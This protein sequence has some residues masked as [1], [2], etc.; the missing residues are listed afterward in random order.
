LGK[1]VAVDASRPD[2]RRVNRRHDHDVRSLDMNLRQDSTRADSD[3]QR[4]F[5]TLVIHLSARFVKV[6]AEQVDSE[7]ADAQRRICDCLQLDSSLL[8]QWRSVPLERFRLTHMHRPLGG[9]PAPGPSEVQA[10]FPWAYEQLLAGRMYVNSSLDDLPPEAACDAASFRRH[11]VKSNVGI[12]LILGGG[13]LLG[14]LTFNTM[15]T[16]RTW[17]E[18]VLQ[19]LQLVA[20]IFANALARKYADADARLHLREL[21]HLNRV[22]TIGVLTNAFAHELNQPLGAILRNTEA[23]ELLLQHEA[24]DLLELRAIVADIKRDDERASGVI[25]RLRALLRQRPIELESVDLVRLVNDVVSLAHSAAAARG[26]WVE[27]DM[28]ATLPAVRCDRVHV[29]QVLLNLIMNGLDAINEAPDGDPRVVI[30]ARTA[31]D[32]Q[33]EVSV[34]DT[35][36]GIAA[37][38]L[39]RLFEPFFTT[40]ASG[41][42]MG[43]AISR[44]L[45]EAHGGR[46]W[47]SDHATRGAT[48]R[49][50]LPTGPTEGIA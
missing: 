5:E 32:H 25:D 11:G 40:K 28:P 45:I 12:P 17:T 18:P 41:T 19:R 29:Q 20:Q 27:G 9:P 43:L 33:V 22:A 35:G 1:V 23:A 24:P 10:T 37:Q 50:T 38:A 7:I 46:L 21:A 14:A 48:F 8:W 44:A 13:P 2:V 16:Q 36:L 3:E 31:G 47:A 39:P 15:Q 34:S 42:G 4:R 6:P 30:R 49:F 26:I